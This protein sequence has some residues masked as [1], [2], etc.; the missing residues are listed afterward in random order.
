MQPFI[1]RLGADYGI[2]EVKPFDGK[3]YFEKLEI[4]DKDVKS[5]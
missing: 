3:F 5:I 1:S 2:V 4:G